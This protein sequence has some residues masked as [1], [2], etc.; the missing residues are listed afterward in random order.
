M[1]PRKTLKIFELIC[2]KTK[3]QLS[4]EARELNFHITFIVNVL[5]SRVTNFKE[6]FR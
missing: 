4:V 2:C 3:R 6:E 1:V 5:L